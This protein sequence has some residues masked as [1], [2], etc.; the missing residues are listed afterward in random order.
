MNRLC[1]NKVL[2]KMNSLE[3]LLI[4]YDDRA[5][6]AY[7]NGD[8]DKSIKWDHRVDLVQKEIDGMEF[9]LHTLGLGAWKTRE[10]EW[11]IPKD[12]ITRAV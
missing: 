4:K 7:Q 2:E 5:T 6:E 12:D 1:I 9:T 10:G 3:R 8:L 11:V